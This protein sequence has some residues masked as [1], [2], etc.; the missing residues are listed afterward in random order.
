MPRPTGAPDARRRGCRYRR[1][2]GEGKHVSGTAPVTAPR[3]HIVGAGIGGLAAA[4]ALLRRGVPVAVHEQAA[5]LGEIGAGVQISANGMR[6]LHAL[7]L[8]APLAA[9]AFEPRGKV[10]RLW[11]TGETWP[12]FDLGAESVRRYGFPYLMFHRADLHAALA[13]AVRAL[14]PGAVRLGAKL[15]ALEEAGGNVRLVFADGRRE[16]VP[17][18]VGAD[19]IHSVVRR[20]L[21]GPDRPRFTGIVA[22]RGVI[23]AERLPPGLLAPVGVNWVGP[24]GHVIH[25]HLRRGA[26]VNF[27]GVRERRDW[28]VES[29]TARGTKAEFHADFAGWHDDIHAM[30]DCVDEP[31]KWALMARDPLPAWSRGA[32]TLLGDACHPMLPFLAQGAVSAVED[33]Y[34]LARAV[35]EAGGDVPAA[36]AR[37]EAARR[38]RTARMMAASAAQAER[39]HNPALAERDAAKRY[40]DEQWQAERVR[41]RYEWLF[42]YDATA[43]P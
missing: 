5:A 39:F 34:V 4:L 28:Q 43:V 24:G 29:W 27:V 18:V 1:R 21:F 32:V 10:V 42:A 15:D 37:Y 20:G 3:I 12:L 31:Y 11:R 7:G 6:V 40:V 13:D 36:F 26:L 14:D 9:V 35:A 33:G 41:E 30:I 17:A 23:P 38:A 2:S 8:E 25:Y 19:G 22:W 16:T